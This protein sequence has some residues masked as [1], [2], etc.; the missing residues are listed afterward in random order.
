MKLEP[1]AL[2]QRLH[3]VGD[4]LA[5]RSG[6]VA[7]VVVGGAALSLGGHAAADRDQTSIHTQDLIALHPTDGELTAA[8]DWVVTQDIGPE[9]PGV[10]DDVVKYVRER[11]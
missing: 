9:F 5:D 1:A 7:I 4:L 11:R 3:A 10:V 6:T 8:R 2:E